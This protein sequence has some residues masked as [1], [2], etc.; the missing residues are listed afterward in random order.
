MKAIIYKVFYLFLLIYLP[1]T[2]SAQSQTVI[3]AEDR[4]ELEK[5]FQELKTFYIDDDGTV[6]YR[7]NG[8][9]STQQ[10]EQIPEKSTKSRVKIKVNIDEDGEYVITTEQPDYTFSKSESELQSIPENIQIKDDLEKQKTDDSSKADEAKSNIDL[11]NTNRNA[12]DL[13]DKKNS[14]RRES[15]YKSLEEAALDLEDLINEYKRAQGQNRRA[16]NSL[17]RKLSGGVDSSI[18]KDYTQTLMDE[19]AI[20]EEESESYGDEPTYYVNGVKVEVSEYKKL[21][22]EDIRTKERRASKV[23]PNGE[24]WVQTR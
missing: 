1:N 19:N 10:E 18:R 9:A 12:E 8:T 21:K 23:N 14:S 15:R 13:L 6:V 2:I 20:Y 16:N 24:W 22:P 11:T 4:R 5:K 17:S 7:Y 3:S